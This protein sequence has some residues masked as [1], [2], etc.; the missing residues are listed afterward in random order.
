[1]KRK[2]KIKLRYFLDVPMARVLF[3]LK[4]FH[5]YVFPC[6]QVL[7]DAG[8]LLL[9][10]IKTLLHAILRMDIFQDPTD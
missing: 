2:S 6:V 7:D 4:E 5:G 10:V 9:A 8:Y 1:M 3:F